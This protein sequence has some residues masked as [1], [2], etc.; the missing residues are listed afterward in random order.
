M[1]TPELLFK[2]GIRKA[3]PATRV[4]RFGFF[5]Q[6]ELKTDLFMRKDGII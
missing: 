4:P 5:T 1:V 2:T 6:R 3:N